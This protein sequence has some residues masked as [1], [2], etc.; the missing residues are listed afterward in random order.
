MTPKQYR[1]NYLITGATTLIPL[2]FYTTA[3]SE[4]LA[5]HKFELAAAKCASKIKRLSTKEADRREASEWRT[6]FQTAENT[7]KIMYCH[8]V[9]Q[10]IQTS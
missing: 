1:I 3:M 7:D 5:I 2:Y 6:R 4:V 10:Q 8:Q 9:T